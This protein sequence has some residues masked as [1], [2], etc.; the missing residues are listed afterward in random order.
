MGIQDILALMWV[1]VNENI[2]CILVTGALAIITNIVMIDMVR[3]VL[4]DTGT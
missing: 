2:G 3:E 4:S 1:G